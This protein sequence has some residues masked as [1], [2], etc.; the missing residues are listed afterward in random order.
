MYALQ[1]SSDTNKTTPKAPS[2]APDANKVRVTVY[3]AYTG[4]KPFLDN[5]KA[6]IVPDTWEEFLASV[7][8]KVNASRVASVETLDTGSV[9]EELNE[10]MHGDKLVIRCSPP[11]TGSTSPN[12]EE[13]NKPS[14]QS[15]ARP[16]TVSN[17]A[18]AEDAIEVVD[19]VT[20]SA[21]S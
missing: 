9:L 3:K 1:A 7:G 5:P 15:G 14:A 10:I 8:R 2:P 16:V 11:P 13:T 21:H 6:V 4:G 12:P 19:I 20:H 17:G 18:D